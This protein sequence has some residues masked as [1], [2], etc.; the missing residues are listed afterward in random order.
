MF[1]RRAHKKGAILQHVWSVPSTRVLLG[2]DI[3]LPAAIC[4]GGDAGACSVLIT[5]WQLWQ[6]TCVHPPCH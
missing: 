2:G 4:V 6:S 1:W 3:C 5:Q